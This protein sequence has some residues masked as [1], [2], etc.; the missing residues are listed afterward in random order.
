MPLS[1]P[2]V[3]PIPQKMHPASQPGS[4]Y[5]L[6]VIGLV[7][8]LP[9]DEEMSPP[10]EAS[11][12]P[13]HR[14]LSLSPLERAYDGDEKCLLRDSQLAAYIYRLD[15]PGIRDAVVDN[16]NTIFGHTVVTDKMI[17]VVLADRDGPADESPRE[18]LEKPR[19]S[20]GRH[21]GKVL[22]RHDV[23]D[24][25]EPRDRRNETVG[26]VEGSRKVDVQYRRPE[27]SEEPQS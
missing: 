11:H 3:V 25:R 5:R 16:P 1:I 7:G 13:E 12:R 27:V 21:H 6:T 4:E 17:D 20:E 22:G 9:D 8:A 2:D 23:L 10:G 19:L 15:P 24:A 14:L 26:R 18:S